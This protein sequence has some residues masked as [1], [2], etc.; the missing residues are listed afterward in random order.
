MARPKFLDLILGARDDKARWHE[1]QARADEL[2]EDYRYVYKKMQGY[3][4]NFAGG[5][6]MDIVALCEDLADLFAEGAADKRAVRDLIGDDPA[7]FCDELIRSADTWTDKWRA[8][9]NKS[10]AEK[11]SA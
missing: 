1:L 4:M 7:A 3:M 5:D 10:I 6:G 8:K 11:L 9:L 2:P